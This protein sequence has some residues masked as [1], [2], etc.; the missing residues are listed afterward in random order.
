M[1]SSYECIGVGCGPSN[2]SLASLLYGSRQVRSIFFDKRSE[3]SWHKGMMLP[4]VGL[5]VSIF[6]D[7]V[8][9]ADPT[10]PFS[11]VSYL[12]KHGRLYQF[13]NARFP[14]VTRQEFG[15]YLKWAAHAN[16]NICFGERV[17]HVDF[18]G[19]QFVVQTP[20]REVFAKNVVVGIGIAPFVPDFARPLLDGE[21]LFH[22]HDF[23]TRPRELGGK[24]VVV[25]GGGQSGAEAVLELLRREGSN[26]PRQV[27]WLSRRDNFLPLD[28]SP[29]ANE[30]FTPSHS[31]YFF[32]QTPEF[33]EEF[34]KRNV[35]ASD[36]VSE[37]TLRDI[38]QRIY[39]M[40]YVEHSTVSVHLLPNREVQEVRRSDVE[41][42]L[43]CRHPTGAA[44]EVCKADVIIWATGFQTAP[45]PFLQRL[46]GRLVYEQGE[47]RIDREF[48]AVWD[49]P[50]NL[51]LLNAARL[52]RG[53]ADPNLSL[54]AWRSQV[55]ISRMAG[56]PLPK[57][58][59]DDPIVSWGALADEVG[60]ERR[61]LLRMT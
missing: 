27:R 57:V 45:M 11:F 46:S 13:L 7:L 39:V 10:S 55:V 6:K 54:T 12:H 17:L 42:D 48:A 5:Q 50:R 51:F 15:D 9:L 52:Q 60:N 40:R 14:Q 37:Q 32:D 34:L 16:E 23:A 53:L 8:M 20:K 44:P 24:R 3:F 1:K 2:L 30:F 21:T 29:F 33:R 56:Q 31:E 22:I 28:D 19:S 43:V 18:D 47:V 49:G 4:N 41:W 59:R 61:E 36:G 25:V 35:L 26:T 58:L 38:Y